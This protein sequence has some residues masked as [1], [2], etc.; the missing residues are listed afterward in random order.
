VPPTLLVV[1]NDGNR[2]GYPDRAEL[3]AQMCGL[4]S[5]ARRPLPEEWKSSILDRD[6]WNKLYKF[7]NRLIRHLSFEHLGWNK[8]RDALCAAVKEYRDLP[9]RKRPASKDFASEFLDGLAQEQTRRTFYLGVQHLKLPHRTRV[10]DARFLLLA[11]DKELAES[12]A[13]LARLGNPMPE[14]VCEVGAIGGTDDLLLERARKAAEGALAVVRQ[15]VLLGMSDS[16]IYLDQ[17]MF[18]LDGTYTWREGPEFRQAGW[19]RQPQPIAMDLTSQNARESLTRLD[20]LSSDYAALAPE[21]R[22]RVDTYIEWLDVAALS[23]RWRII[24]PAVF[25]A[26]ESLLVPERTGLK[27]GVVTVRSVAVHVAVGSGFFDPADTM[28]GYD[29]R[30]DLIHGTPTPDVSDRRA[31]EFAESRRRWAFEVLD[32]YLKL[33]KDIG[34][35]TVK[36]IVAHLDGG[37]CD[38]V[39][40]WLDEQ[41]GSAIVA[42]YRALGGGRT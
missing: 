5:D 3:I 28:N 36:Q 41:G 1:A 17:V 35:V 37:P 19:W 38:E 18:G 26:M 39:C 2:V 10:G 24:I 40:T 6:G 33:A 34:A 42:E 7:A 11:E 15:Y 21:L 30:S 12:F 25:S 29:L 4:L 9:P 13:P 8:L 14:L 31:T 27:A 22:E 20:R 23:N 32:D 16:K